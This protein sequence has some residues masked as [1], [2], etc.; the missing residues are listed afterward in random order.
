MS[1]AAAKRRIGIIST[2]VSLLVVE[3]FV[4]G[5]NIGP[6]VV[7][8]WILAPL[9]VWLV[10]ALATWLLPMIFIKKRVEERRAPSAQG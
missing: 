4:D 9:I 2:F 7:L 10:T 6:P 5:L 3:S 1:T 8:T